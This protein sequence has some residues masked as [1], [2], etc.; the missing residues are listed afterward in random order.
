MANSDRRPDPQVSRQELRATPAGSRTRPRRQ[1]AVPRVYERAAVPAWDWSAD[2]LSAAE[3][4]ELR[5]TV[6]ALRERIG[7]LER[8]ATRAHERERELRDALRKLAGGGLRQR[9]RLTG[10]LRDRGLL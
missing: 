5:A 8:A 6:S 3:L 7:E 10:E 4:A 1:P 9:R 2:E